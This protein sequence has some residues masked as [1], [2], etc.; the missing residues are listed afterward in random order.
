MKINKLILFGCILLGGGLW[1]YIEYNK[2]YDFDVNSVLE[3]S[4]LKNNKIEL[5]VEEIDFLDGK[6][7]AYFMEDKSVELVSIS[8]GFDKSGRAYENKLGVGLLAKNLLLDGAGIYDRKDIRKIMKE[9]GI[10]IGVDV[11]NDKLEMSLSYVKKFQKDAI[12]LLK[13]IMYQP[14]LNK[15]DLELIKQ[16]LEVSR[17][18]LN[19][20]PQYQLSKLIKKEFYGEHVYGRENIP[21]KEELDTITGDDIRQYL[22]EFMVKENLKIGVAGNIKKEELISVLDDIFYDLLD[23]AKN[24]ENIKLD[25]KQKGK[26]S[27]ID[28]DVSRQSFVSFIRG[29]IGRLDRDFYPLYIADYIFGG[30]GLTSRLNISIREKEGLTYGIYSY[31]SNSDAIDLWTVGFSSTPDNVDKIINIFNEEYDNFINNGI[32]ENELNW[33]K[34]SLLASFNLRFNNLMNMSEMLKQMQMQNL[35]RDFLEQRQSYIKEITLNDVNEALKRW[36]VNGGEFQI[37]KV[38]GKI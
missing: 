28:F 9:K 36:K 16:Q 38:N 25:K 12:D 27:S 7:T 6:N 10:K 15:E 24:K 21:S 5:R 4:K 1:A 8:F 20:S 26:I 11:T 18:R 30:S 19:E 33:A 13:A 3:K 22:K 17:N 31:F 32:T 23:E 29:G 37:F 34:K 35:G 14:H 2:Y